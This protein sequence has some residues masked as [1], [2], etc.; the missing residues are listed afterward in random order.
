MRLKGELLGRRSAESLWGSI[1][2]ILLAV[3]NDD[4]EL[5]EGALLLVYG[6][7]VVTMWREGSQ[8][9]VGG[10]G[11]K[12]GLEGGAPRNPLSDSLG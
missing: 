7:D 9:R 1:S 6:D 4:C 11:G 10:A 5:G 8:P 12:A 2:R 3:N